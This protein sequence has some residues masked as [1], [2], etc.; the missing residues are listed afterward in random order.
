MY[1]ETPGA[2]SPARPRPPESIAARELSACFWYNHEMFHDE[3]RQ[4]LLELCAETGAV[5]ARIVHAKPSALADRGVHRV[6]LG[7]GAHLDV[8]MTAEPSEAQLAAIERAARALR[9]CARRW[10]LPLPPL[11]GEPAAVPMRTRIMGRVEAF[12]RGLTGVKDA[13]NALVTVRGKLV[14]SA[15]PPRELERERIDFMLRRVDAEVARQVGASSHTELCGP[16]FYAT[17]FWYGACLIVFFEGPFSVDFIRH[18]ARMVTRELASLL[19]E[20]DDPP[21]DPAKVAPIPPE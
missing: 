21:R 11:G 14:A 3:L 7:V 20:L 16:D 12:L 8:E 6:P 13:A 5:D 10:E 9:D 18:R 19:P 2:P 17:S 15:N 1:R 4:R